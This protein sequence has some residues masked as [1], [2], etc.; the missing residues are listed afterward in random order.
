MIITNC[1]YCNESQTFG[2]EDGDQK[3]YFASRCYICKEV[4]WV[5]ATPLG[6]TTYSHED[7]KEMINKKLPYND[8]LRLELMKAEAVCLSGVIYDE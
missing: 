1:P 7:F 2:W 4:M 6:R 8:D 5:E 3:G